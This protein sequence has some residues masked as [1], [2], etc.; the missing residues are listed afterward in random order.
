LQHKFTTINQFRW[1]ISQWFERRWWQRYLDKK[2]P[3]D[4]LAWKQQYWKDFLKKTELS[5]D[6]LKSPIIDIGCGPAGIFTVLNQ[7]KVSALDPLVDTYE[8]DLEIFEKNQF[9]NVDFVCADFESHDFSGGEFATVFCINAVNHFIHL[10]KSMSK[11]YEI[12]KD[13]GM[14]ILSVDAHNFSFFKYLFRLIPLDILHPHQYDLKEYKSMLA[15]QGFS[16][17]KTYLH[18]KSFFFDYWIIKAVK[19]VTQ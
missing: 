5:A 17:E 14:L 2:N 10:E 18:R 13:G 12:T 1:K 7:A 4:Y 16:I 6:T 19:P 11:L 15:I 8:N 3:A 9:K